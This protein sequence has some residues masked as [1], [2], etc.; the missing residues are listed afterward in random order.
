MSFFLILQDAA[1]LKESRGTG[2]KRQDGA[3]QA[4]QRGAGRRGEN[5][6]QAVVT[7]TSEHASHA[8]ARTGQAG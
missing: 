8:L 5:I 1:R 6:R 4:G 7:Q 3:G 2:G